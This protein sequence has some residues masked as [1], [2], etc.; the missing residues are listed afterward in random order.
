[1]REEMMKWKK[2]YNLLSIEVHNRCLTREMR[3]DRR[4]KFQSVIDVSQG[5][6]QTI[7]THRLSV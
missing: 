1:M 3:F 6:W 5:N 4:Y 2:A 7:K